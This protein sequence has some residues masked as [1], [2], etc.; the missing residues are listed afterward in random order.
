MKNKQKM[1]GEV[2]AISFGISIVLLLSGN[3]VAFFTAVGKMAD[4]LMDSIAWGYSWWWV[5][6]PILIGDIGCIVM[7]I[8]AYIC[9]HL[10]YNARWKTVITKPN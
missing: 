10:S 1:W 4:C 5:G 9:E 3:G 2:S 8:M 6:L 7:V